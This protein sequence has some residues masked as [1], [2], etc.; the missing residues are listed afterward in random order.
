MPNENIPI[1]NEDLES[2]LNIAAD[3]A[4]QSYS[5]YSNFRVGAAVISENRKIFS[6]CNIENRS[7]PAGICAEITAISKLISSGE[8]KIC[9]IAVVGLDSDNFLPPCGVC[10]QF[11]TEFGNDFPVLMANK[12]MEYQIISVA[13]LLPSDSLHDLKK[14]EIK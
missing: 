7:Y 12:K 9:A 3:A 6:G 10:R 2:L 1:K 14:Y 8:K 4:K 11:M 5:P 13:Q